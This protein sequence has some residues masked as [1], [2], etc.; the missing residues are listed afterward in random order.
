MTG[1]STEST[2][3]GEKVAMLVALAPVGMTGMQSA[4][5]EIKAA[6][7]RQEIRA[8]PIR[9][10]PCP[11]ARSRTWPRPR[12]HP[13][14]FQ[15]YVMRDEEFV[16]NIIERAKAGQLLG[17]GADA[18]PADPRAS[19]GS[20]ERS[21]PPPKLTAAGHAG[22]GDEMELG[23][24]MLQTKRRS[25]GNIVGHAKGRRRHPLADE[26]DGRAVRP[27]ARLGQDRPHP[28][29]VGRQADPEGGINDP[30]DARMAADFGADAIVVSNH[31]GR[32]LD[33]AVSSIRMLP[34]I[35]AAVGDQIEIHLDSGIRSGQDVLKALAMG[36][37]GTMIGRAYIY[38]P[39]RHGRGRRHQGA[40]GHPEGTDVTMALCG[41]RCEPSWP[42]Q[43]Y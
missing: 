33:G 43:P 14:W 42:P 9:C 24:E 8:C 21:V 2:L 5:G 4:D 35:V 18:G 1:R 29:P 19:E 22:S 40:G 10:R 39:W 26:L 30:D 15:L 20:E 25:F 12:R 13:F 41:E 31:G 3:I 37:H 28:R 34:E 6:Q 7:G 16:E 23:I 38:G 32:Q 27:Q 36:A 17:A 11:S